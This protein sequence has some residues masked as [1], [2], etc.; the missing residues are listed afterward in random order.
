MPNPPQ[1]VHSIRPESYGLAHF[2]ILGN[3]PTPT[4]QFED[5]DS[6]AFP[7]EVVRSGD[8]VIVRVPGNIS[9]EV[10]IGLITLS[11]AEEL[12]IEVESPSIPV[13]VMESKIKIS[14]ILEAGAYQEGFN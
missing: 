10:G 5:V 7:A 1:I 8:T 11:N 4:A 6:V 14:D 3:D 13:K 2:Y 9:M 12:E